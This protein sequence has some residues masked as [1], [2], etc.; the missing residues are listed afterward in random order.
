MSLA[1]GKQEP[2]PPMSVAHVQPQPQPLPPQRPRQPRLGQIGIASWYGR[3]FAGKRTA[4]GERFDPNA[5]TAA[6][7]A[8]SDAPLT[9]AASTDEIMRFVFSRVAV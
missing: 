9:P 8:R 1:G 4:N 5:L 3:A 6:H 2:P 7:I